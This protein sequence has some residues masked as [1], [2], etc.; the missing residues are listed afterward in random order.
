VSTTTFQD[1]AEA[2]R[3]LGFTGSTND[4][5]YAWLRGLGYEG[6]LP[7]MFYQYLRSLGYAGSISD[8]FSNLTLTDLSGNTA[9]LLTTND[10]EAIEFSDGK[11]LG[12]KI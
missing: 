1:I 7:D 6:A 10:G 11:Y 2:L 12:V 5:I 3:P 8:M 9:V 4:I